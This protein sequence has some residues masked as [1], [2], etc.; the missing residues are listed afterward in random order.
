MHLYQGDT[1]NKQTNNNNN[2]NDDDD[3]DKLGGFPDSR[4][5]AGAGT[6][7]FLT[8]AACLVL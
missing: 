2:N 8:A 7:L 4:D 3:D 1:N 5:G 6:K